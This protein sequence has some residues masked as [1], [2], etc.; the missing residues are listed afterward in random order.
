MRLPA[1]LL[2]RDKNVHKYDFGHV[3]VIAGSARMLGTAALVSTAAMRAGAGLVTIAI[4]RS[5]NNALHKKIN[6][7]VM[8]WPLDETKEGTLSINAL[9]RIKKEYK[10]FDAIAIGPGLSQNP[11]TQKLILKLIESSP[12]PLVVDADAL[13]ALSGRLHVLRKTDTVKILTPH[14][15]EMARLVKYPGNEID[16]NK[17]KIVKQF[18]QHHRVVLLL[19]GFQTLIAQEGKK[20]YLN[21]TGNAGM[22]TAGS[23]DVL[24][25]IIAAFLAQG[26]NGFDAARYGAYIHGKAG[27]RAAKKNSK[28]S[29]IATDIIEELADCLK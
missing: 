7:V 15:G 9:S 14:L 8:T 20:V 11:Q 12:V 2:R 3:L 22:A 1:P 29:L 5:L 28:T 27:D 24:T 25:G 26:L 21:K 4:P 23:G 17:F 6:P 18:A 19:K 13:N 10:R 16:K